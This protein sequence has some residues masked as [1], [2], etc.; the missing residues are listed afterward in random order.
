MGER[1]WSPQPGQPS[2]SYGGPAPLDQLSWG[3]AA[4]APPKATRQDVHPEG[5]CRVWLFGRR[6]GEAAVA[7]GPAARQK[8]E[9]EERGGPPS[10]ARAGP[11]GWGEEAGGA[12]RPI[13]PTRLGD[14]RSSYDA[15]LGSDPS[16]AARS[17]GAAR[18]A[19]AKPGSRPAE[20]LA[21]AERPASPTR[22][23]AQLDS[24]LDLPLA[25]TRWVGRSSGG[26]AH[27]LWYRRWGVARS[28]RSPLKGSSGSNGGALCFW[29]G[30]QRGSIRRRPSFGSHQRRL[31]W[32]KNGL[33]LFFP[34][35]LLLLFANLSG[36]ASVWF[37]P[38][39]DGRTVSKVL[40]GCLASRGG[41]PL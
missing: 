5:G 37:R 36:G 1:K 3:F 19:R 32:A 21:P 16:R 17:L 25:K 23:K 40:P 33:G 28:P 8:W 9:Q 20:S 18:T 39:Q 29:R 12:H 22:W 7:Q 30:Q 38:S 27:G 14:G 15:L 35:R 6:A 26:R 41:R 31:V 2:L 4:G 10:G 24:P 11:R 34:A 13:R